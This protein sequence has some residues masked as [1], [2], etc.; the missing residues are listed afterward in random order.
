MIDYESGDP[1]RGCGYIYVITLQSMISFSIGNGMEKALRKVG[2]CS[3]RRNQNSSFVLIEG[4]FIL[5][6]LGKQRH[7]IKY[8][9]PLSLGKRRN[10]YSAGTTTPKG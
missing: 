10:R 9:P 6:Y 3:L 1:I 7:S 4:S 2:M 8:S 5:I